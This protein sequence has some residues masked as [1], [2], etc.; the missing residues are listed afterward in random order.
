MGFVQGQPPN[1]KCF[2]VNPEAPTEILRKAAYDRLCVPWGLK[3]AFAAGGD[4]RAG[5]VCELTGRRR[6]AGRLSPRRLANKGAASPCPFPLFAAI[7]STT[8]S[9]D[10]LKSATHMAV[11]WQCAP[12]QLLCA[13][14]QR[15]AQDTAP[16]RQLRRCPHQHYLERASP[17]P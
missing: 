14:C 6:H 10:R 5:A 1:D 15:A 11:S 12:R 4:S 3:C 7:W 16:R 9:S 13:A 17:E 2:V 8:P